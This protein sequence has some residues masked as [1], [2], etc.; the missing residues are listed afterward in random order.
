MQSFVSFADELPKISRNEARPLHPI[1]SSE[2]STPKAMK[3]PGKHMISSVV[4]SKTVFVPPNEEKNK[5][6]T[7]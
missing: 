3:S 4:K 2:Y 5:K 7:G 6:S 1:I